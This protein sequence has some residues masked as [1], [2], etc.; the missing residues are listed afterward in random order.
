M[1]SEN[2]DFLARKTLNYI[3]FVDLIITFVSALLMIIFD[4]AQSASLEGVLK[5][6]FAIGVSVILLF[7]ALA[8]IETVLINIM[9]R[10]I[11]KYIEDKEF[12]KGVNYIEKFPKFKIFYDIYERR[13]YYLGLLNLYLDNIEKAKSSFYRI[14]IKSPMLESG[15]FI[16]TILYLLLICQENL[17][18]QEKEYIKKCFNDNINKLKKNKYQY[19][20]NENGINAI[21]K[22]LDNDISDLNSILNNNSEIPL[23]NRILKNA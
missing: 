4:N 17:N 14:N 11:I 6:I 22:I 3:F 7:F 19:K 15:V 2:N 12:E 8:V 10:K 5:P 23:I 16:N 9:N 20:L 13:Y 21:Q 18:E 1:F